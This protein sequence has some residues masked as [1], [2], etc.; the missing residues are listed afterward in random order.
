MLDFSEHEDEALLHQ[1]YGVGQVAKLVASAGRHFGGELALA[2]LGGYLGE[3]EDVGG[4]AAREQ[5]GQKQPPDYCQPGDALDYEANF[6]LNLRKLLAALCDLAHAE[7]GHLGGDFLDEVGLLF[8][9]AV[10]GLVHHVI[11]FGLLEFFDDHLP[12][13]LVGGHRH[14]GLVKFGQ[15]RGVVRPGE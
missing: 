4:K 3:L 13:Y 14:F 11:G 9:G 6:R 8:E 5:R 15:H 1:L 10:F 7:F 2:D 12:L